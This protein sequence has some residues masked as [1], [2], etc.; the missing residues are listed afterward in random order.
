MKSGN[1]NIIIFFTL[2]VVML[3]FGMII[4]HAV[5]IVLRRQRPLGLLMALYGL[6]QF[7]FAPFWAAPTDL[8]VSRY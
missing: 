7:L 8:V 1:R 6:M 2:V 4:R 3:G 5:Y